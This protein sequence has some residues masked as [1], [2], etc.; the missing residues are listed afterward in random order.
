LKILEDLSPTS[1][2]K[3]SYDSQSLFKINS[4]KQITRFQGLG[5]QSNSSITREIEESIFKTLRNI[6]LEFSH[7]TDFKDKE[8]P[9]EEIHD[10][11]H[12][13]DLSASEETTFDT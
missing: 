3:Q 9:N 2:R 7:P 6:G 8:I 1:S 10:D 11:R 5:L 13:V 12:S 4:G